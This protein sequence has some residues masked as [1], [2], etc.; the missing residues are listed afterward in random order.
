LHAILRITY[1][2]VAWPSQGLRVERRALCLLGAVMIWLGA[3]GAADR[4]AAE[5]APAPEDERAFGKL[6]TAHLPVHASAEDGLD[7]RLAAR[8]MKIA[9]PL[10]IRIFKAESE[11]EMWMKAGERFELLA[12]YPICNW[13]GTLGPKLREGDGQSPEGLYAIG[14]RQLHRSARWRR[15]LDI[16]YPNAFD[17]GHART[18]SS[19]LVHGGCT[20]TGC[21]AMT[22]RVMEQIFRLSRAALWNG[23]K[24][25]AVHIFPFR[26]TPE[27]MA[28]HAG[29][30]WQGFW[31]NLKEA[32]DLF[33]RTRLPPAVKVCAHRYVVSE[34]GGDDGCPAGV[35]ATTTSGPLAAP[36]RSAAS[37]KVVGRRPGRNARKAYA[38]ARKARLAA[39]VSRVKPAKHRHVQAVG[40]RKLPR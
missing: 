34:A 17:R 18:G 33:E 27:N 24:R 11:L 15:S 39:R 35:I 3:A 10:I 30:R 32:Y 23:Q 38:D 12:S 20:S 28:A 29:S 21:F 37:V 26:M 13:A 6:G 5:R 31:A 2:L 8:G 25:I 14:R 1:N 9:S 7:Q 40:Y 16:G 4:A 36:Q 19:I 22:D